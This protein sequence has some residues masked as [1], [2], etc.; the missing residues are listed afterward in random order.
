M[1]LRESYYIIL[2][3][4]L[5]GLVASLHELAHGSALISAHM[6]S[7]CYIQFWADKHVLDV[8]V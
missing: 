1:N 8:P 4:V 7:N 2:K 5:L 3:Y 6:L